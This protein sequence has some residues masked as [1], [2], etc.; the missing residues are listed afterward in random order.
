[1]TCCCLRI[2]MLRTMHIPNLSTPVGLSALMLK[3][4]GEASIGQ[5]ALRRG[6]GQYS[7]KEQAQ[8]QQRG[9]CHEQEWQ[10]TR[11]STTTTHLYHNNACRQAAAGY[12]NYCLH[13]ITTTISV[14]PGSMKPCA[15]GEAGLIAA[16]Q[17]SK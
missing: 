7:L 8:G 17:C 15:R 5:G 3:V 14:S 11:G 1:M 13:V 10:E 12:A 2:F 4:G 9:P 6:Q 16:D